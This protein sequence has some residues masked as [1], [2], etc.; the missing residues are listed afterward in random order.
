MPSDLHP[1][2]TRNLPHPIALPPNFHYI[3]AP[4]HTPSFLTKTNPMNQIKH[5][6]FA[7]LLCLIAINGIYSQQ[8]NLAAGGDATGAGGSMGYSIG[9]VDYLMYSSDQGNLSFGLQQPW[10]YTIPPIYEIPNIII[11]DG[12]TLCFNATET[13]IVAGDGKQFLVQTGGHADIIAGQNIIM[14]YG[15]SIEHGGSLHAFISNVFCDQPES[16]LASFEEQIQ[17]EP[18]FEPVL[19]E[20]FFK[21]YPNPTTGDFT[22]ELLDFEESSILLIEI[23]TMQGHL[24]T[25]NELPAQRHYNLSL[26]GRQPGIYLVRIIKDY[27]IETSKIIKQ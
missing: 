27:E 23:Y 17:P 19:K 2:K 16:L 22:L 10:T 25:R 24:I 7:C 13:V 15:T 1:Q 12:E 5:P 21:V 8:G 26:A 14:R 11:G 9:Q 6:L 18:V 3:A 4:N 20:T